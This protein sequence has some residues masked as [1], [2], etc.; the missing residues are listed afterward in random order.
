MSIIMFFNLNYILI[1]VVN[2]VQKER[3]KQ[4]V[5]LDVEMPDVDQAADVKFTSKLQLLWMINCQI[6]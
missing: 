6:C 4:C 2:V 5:K 3:P 1:N